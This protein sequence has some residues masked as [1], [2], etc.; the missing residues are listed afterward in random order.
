MVFALIIPDILNPFFTLVARGAEDCARERGYSLSCATR[1]STLPERKN[2]WGSHNRGGRRHHI[3]A[4]VGRIS[5][6]AQ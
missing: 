6:R 2:T 3:Y 5:S 4:R 1:W